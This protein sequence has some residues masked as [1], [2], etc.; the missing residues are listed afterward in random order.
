[1]EA[2]LKKKQNKWPKRIFRVVLFLF[3]FLLLI[4]ALLH[5]PAVQN[6][7]VDKGIAGITKNAEADITIGETEVNIW[8][9]IEIKDV[10]AV[11]TKGDTIISIN[12][13]S[14]SPTNT[15]LAL[16][17]NLITGDEI[18]FN[19]LSASGVT[20]NIVKAK[21]ETETNLASLFSSEKQTGQQEKKQSSP[22]TLETLRLNDFSLR[23]KDENTGE[24]LNGDFEAFEIDIDQADFGGDAPLI[25]IDRLLLLS[26]EV[27]YVAGEKVT[28]E[29][30]EDES[31]GDQE[32]SEQQSQLPSISIGAIELISGQLDIRGSQL[33][34]LEELDLVLTDVE[35]EDT[36]DWSGHLSQL[37]GTY[38]GKELSYASI[39]SFSRKAGD[40][41]IDQFQANINNSRLKFDSQIQGVKGIMDLDNAVVD[42]SL[43]PTIFYLEDLFPFSERLREEWEGEPISTKRVQVSGGLSLSQS[44]YIARDLSLWINGL[45]HFNGDVSFSPG[46]EVGDNI[47]N[48]NVKR[49]YADMSDLSRLTSKFNLPKELIRLEQVDFT[50]SFDGFL[51]NFVANGALSTPLGDAQ[52]DIKFDLSGTGDDAVSYAGYL[53]LDSFDLRGM[54]LDSNFGFAMAKVNINNGVGPDL[55]S[56]SADIKA[57]IDALE[58]RGYTYRDAVYEGRL[59]SG[60]IDGVFEIHDEVLDFSF[61]GLV[62]FQESTP[63]FDFEISA[64]RID[65]CQL[66]LT[67]FPC[68]VAFTSDI[69]LS[70]KDLKSMAGEVVV[71]NILLIQDTTELAI[72]HIEINSQVGENHNTFHLASDFVDFDIQGRFN[73]I[74]FVP[75]TFNR[76]LSNVSGHNEVWKINYDPIVKN[77]QNYSFAL[78]VKDITPVMSFLNIPVVLN[79]QAYLTGVQKSNLDLIT[80]TAS[81]PNIEYDGNKAENIELEIGSTE[82]SATLQADITGLTVG[83]NSFENIAV[84][85]V[86]DDDRVVWLLDYKI[87]SLN[88]G[89]LKGTSEVA[90]QGY[91]THISDDDLFIDGKKWDVD[92]YEGVGISP[93]F[94]DIKKLSISDGS[95]YVNISD[96]ENKGLIADI[97][98]FELSFINPIIDYD[99]TIFTGQIKSKVLIEDVFSQTVIQGEVQVDDFQVNGDDFGVLKIEAKRDE[100][101]NNK[102]DVD[103]SIKKDTQN[104]YVQG[105]VDVDKQELESSIRIEDYPMSFFEYIIEDGISDTEGTTDIEARIFGP[106]NDLDVQGEGVVK[107]GGVKIDF[108]GAFYR[109]DDQRIKIS[110]TFIDLTDT[111][112]IDAMDNVAVIEGGLR[113]NFF[114]DIKADATISSDRFIGLSTTIEDNPLYYGTGVGAIEMSFDGPFDAIDIEVSA[115]LQNLSH[116][117]VP[118]ASSSYVYDESFII[119]GGKIDSAEQVDPQSLVDLLKKQGVDFKM[120]LTFTRDAKVS[121]IYDELTDNVLVGT[122]EGS[123]QLNV[124]RDGDFTVYG[125]YDVI[126]GEY[127]FT[128]YNLIAKPF[129]IQSGGKVTWTGDPYNANLDVTAVYP[130]LRAPLENLL[131]EFNVINENDLTARRLIDL[132]LTLTGPL[133]NPDINFDIEFPNLT[134]EIRTFAQSKVNTLKATENGINNQVVG[135]L[136]FNNF[137]P[138]NNGFS[139]IPI[140]AYG[141]TGANTVTQF[142]TSQLSNIFSD[143]LTSK[144]GDDDFISAIDFEIG[145]AQSEA[146]PV[147]QSLDVVP[148]EFQVN[149]RN[150]FRNNQFVLNLGGNYVRDQFGQDDNFVTGDFSLDWFITD[151]R[152][153]KLRFYGNFDYDYTVATRRQRYGFG[154]NF[155]KEFGKIADL[156]SV[157]DEIIEQVNE[158]HAT[159][160]SE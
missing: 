101:D 124:T 28:T 61:A 95:R 107:N 45:H 1:M 7:L 83:G 84:E 82:G 135:L 88:T 74:K 127:L 117:Y 97:N 57:T 2:E 116:L 80:L 81:I 154:I 130:G 137:L 138:D 37:S 110:K 149:L 39:H 66:N 121:I 4:A 72:E 46:E 78:K 102:I 18:G 11:G 15:V 41:D 16:I 65:F 40:L 29:E 92:S 43:K 153:L 42:L 109:M 141:Q 35:F 120:A 158:Q 85:T 93:S 156:E 70:G 38:N 10:V 53:E 145:L 30:S 125:D 131:R 50:G 144:L 54:T 90:N 122:G 142:L 21:N 64:K 114:A 105:Y 58:Y 27:T 94:L 126:E 147:G 73:L 87:D 8:R 150:Y 49:V 67:D 103:V 32:S 133:F 52:M 23:Y 33:L 139:Q 140:G 76:V 108:I 128:A 123:I 14:V 47:L 9:G 118:L 129:N 44:N 17:G 60:V 25:D 99:K 71:D 5:L 48:A 69:N 134:G 111:Q 98:D 75:E 36:D 106:L 155:R 152:R 100:E 136:I 132:Q 13:I 24:E 89:L 119:L 79:D 148:E 157:V 151:D 86:L 20:L 77:D 19:K 104:L 3:L 34:T 112:I 55:S 26:P 31:T 113:H 143:Y 115:E 146:L 22:P 51:E 59:S 12:E 56:S 91:M 62:N 68:Q 6:L 160:S 159:S 96:Y 63:I